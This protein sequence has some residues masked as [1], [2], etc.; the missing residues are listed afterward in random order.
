M[1]II[2]EVKKIDAQDWLY[3]K[4]IGE[5][6]MAV[7]EHFKESLVEALKENQMRNLLLDF[8]AVDFIDSSGLG[9]ILGRYRTLAQVGGKIMIYGVNQQVYR[10]LVASG[11]N[12][13]IDV[14]PAKAKSAYPANDY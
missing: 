1:Q 5:I 9:V 3:T 7:S 4:L 14:F 10:L 2:F 8:S 13:V 11:L 6:D 12:K